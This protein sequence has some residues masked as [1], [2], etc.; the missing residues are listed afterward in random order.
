MFHVCFRPQP[1]AG[2]HAHLTAGPGRGHG[3]QS[4]SWSSALESAL[5][6]SYG[7]GVAL[8]LPAGGRAGAQRDHTAPGNVEGVPVIGRV[9]RTSALQIR[10]AFLEPPRQFPAATGPWSTAC[11]ATSDTWCSFVNRIVPVEGLR[12]DLCK[13]R[14]IQYTNNRLSGGSQAIKRALDLALAGD[15]RCPR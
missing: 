10:V 5:R 12:S 6:E 11:S 2:V 15:A 3:G 14:S 9:E 1:G 13:C 8:R 7:D 4:R